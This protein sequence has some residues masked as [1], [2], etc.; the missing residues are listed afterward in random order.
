MTSKLLYVT[1]VLCLLLAVALART[2]KSVGRSKRNADFPSH[3]KD[4]QHKKAEAAPK[5]DDITSKK[6]EAAPK[7]D[8]ITSKKVEAAPKKDDIA[9]KKVEAAP[10]KD[11]GKDKKFEYDEMTQGK[12]YP[13]G[14]ENEEEEEEE[15][16]HDYHH[17]EKA[18]GK[19]KP[20]G[21]EDED[22][23]DK[24]DYHH[25]EKPHGKPNNHHKDQYVKAFRAYKLITYVDADCKG[26]GNPL[27]L[28]NSE[29]FIL[30]NGDSIHLSVTGSK[31]TLLHFNTSVTCE[32]I[33]VDD[34]INQEVDKCFSRGS[35]SHK[36][37]P[38]VIE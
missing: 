19:P 33:P 8:D 15:D 13:Y 12:K 27:V 22:E 21:H 35:L 17:D 26:D 6:A 25:D 3:P 2:K 30:P 34:L 16:K 23:E 9:S 5:K 1:L 10:K 24:H 20:Y 4:N 28:E 18:H 37:V 38:V 29:C 14:F 36:I 7:K 31:A 32:G 11:E